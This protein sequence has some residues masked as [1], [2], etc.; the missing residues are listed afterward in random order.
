[1]PFPAPATPSGSDSAPSSS[2]DISGLRSSSG[3][4]SSR[5]GLDRASERSGRTESNAGPSAARELGSRFGGRPASRGRDDASASGPSGL[6][7]AYRRQ[8]DSDRGSERA[9]DSTSRSGGPSSRASGS[10]DSGSRSGDAA[11][12]SGGPRSLS[13][14]AGPS[15][16]E[17]DRG[18]VRGVPPA[19]DG[20]GREGR[21]SDSAGRGGRPVNGFDGAR[22]RS[23]R[24]ERDLGGRDV[25]RERTGPGNLGRP[26]GDGRIGGLEDAGRLTRLAG[27][28]P[29]RSREIGRIARRASDL[30]GRAFRTGFGAGLGLIGCSGWNLGF[31]YWDNGWSFWGGYGH[32]YGSP[33]WSRYGYWWG[34]GCYPYSY[35]THPFS[36]PF[37]S[38]YGYWPR[39]RYWYPSSYYPLYYSYPVYTASVITR[40][41]YDEY[42]YGGGGDTVIINEGDDVYVETG[43]THEVY[44]Q[45][46]AVAAP[47]A[48]P[49]APA[50]GGVG[51][52]GFPAPADAEA[53]ATEGGDRATGQ[54][55]TLGDQAFRDGR[56][57]D[58]VH[59]YARAVQFT[60]DN[61][62]LWLVL[63]D[64]LFATG[65][66][67]YG[68]FAL[69]KALAL[70]P[71]LA[72]S[73]VDKRDFYAD[74]GDF[75]RQ[76]AVLE[77]FVQDHPSDTDA[78]LMLAA[79]YL[80]GSRPAAAVDLIEGP[81][82]E[83]LRADAAAG[84]L[85]EAARTVQ[86]GR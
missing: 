57:A 75:D 26:R 3:P 2:R 23:G 15:F 6:R 14:R 83:A 69:R 45:G 46:E 5:F 29:T 27:S 60:P 67:H 13:D 73:P 53:Q 42:D 20:R 47:P 63:S 39:V 82:S 17:R 52:G 12:R 74:A 18:S 59:F 30:T 72:E 58:A 77:G 9:P 24:S 1:M 54:Y 40:Y 43:Q 31:G 55:L 4:S 22:G 68:A 50:T 28:D 36:Y 8:T 34:L 33:Y 19:G 76:L 61:G 86:Y 62:V 66:Y 70:E 84:V 16:G 48:A 85:L 32:G 49:A 25:P 51:D 7:E 79:N 56:F 81:G 44:D 38:Y 80:F 78:R 11:S 65:D 41:V 37:Y 64:G 71:G 35:W 21:D 10:R